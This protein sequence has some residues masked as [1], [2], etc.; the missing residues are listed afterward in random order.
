ML[1]ETDQMVT[2]NAPKGS[3]T[4]KSSEKGVG[5]SLHKFSF[6]QVSNVCFQ[7]TSSFDLIRVRHL[8]LFF[9]FRSS[10]PR[11]LSM[12]CLNTLLKVKCV[13]SWMGRTL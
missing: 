8:S 11:Q 10:D 13:V 12:S 6:S 1:I 7:L 9:N 4:M 3:A 5:V 2:L